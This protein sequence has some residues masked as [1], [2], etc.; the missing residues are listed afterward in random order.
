[1]T[2]E[3]SAAALL[4][5]VIGVIWFLPPV[6]TAALV[7]FVLTLACVEY[8]RLTR[9]AGIAG[10]AAAAVG[11]I[12]LGLPLG[13]MVALAL[14]TG[15]EAVLLLLATVVVSDT[16]QY[17]GGRALGRRPL[18][19]TISPRKTVEGAICGVLAA[20]AAFTL[21]GAW[22]MPALP[23]APRMALGAT[24]ALLGIGG[25]LFESRLKRAAD[26]KDASNLIPGH[27]G[28]LDRIDALLFAAPVYYAVIVAFAR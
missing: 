25:D 13:A 18:A 15:R 5:I 9:A 26:V 16:A 8:A 24:L 3:F 10:P 20:T 22:W 23:P 6:A 14:E 19:P 28:I 27:G 1:M 17:Y 21:I 4:P 2:R 12:Y 11:V 7:G